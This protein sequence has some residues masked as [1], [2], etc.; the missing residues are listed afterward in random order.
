MPHPDEID[1]DIYSRDFALRAKELLHQF[2]AE[3]RGQLLLYAGLEL[4]MGIEARLHEYLGSTLGQL[5][6]SGE[7]VREFTAS[8]LLKKLLRH[9]D[10]AALGAHVALVS[11]QRE[12]GLHLEFRPVTPA[13]AAAHGKIS[14]FLHFNYFRS[15][16]DW[17]HHEAVGGEL[18]T[19]LD[20]RH[21]LG[22]VVNELEYVTEGTL[23]THPS[24][25]RVVEETLAERGSELQ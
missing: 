7:R 23:F 5:G 6:R 16:P 15:H 21:F 13:L 2:D 11:E 9:D 17:S 19:L 8:H 24:F 25:K 12:L 18:I 1:L 14:G 4:R 22:Q 10:S 20:V 3:R